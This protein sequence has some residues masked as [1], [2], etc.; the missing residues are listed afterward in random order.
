MNKSIPVQ[1]SVE[2][3]KEKNNYGQV[4]KETILDGTNRNV[5]TKR[6]KD[7]ETVNSTS[8]NVSIEKSATSIRNETDYFPKHPQRME[9]K[10]YKK[11]TSNSSLGNAGKKM[12]RNLEKQ[13]AQHN[14]RDS[15]RT[16]RVSQNLD[17]HAVEE[18]QANSTQVSLRNQNEGN[19]E[20]TSHLKSQIRTP[21]VRDTSSDILSK[22][23]KE[24]VNNTRGLH[25]IKNGDNV[26]LN[27][28]APLEN[29]VKINEPKKINDTAEK[30]TQLEKVKIN[31]MEKN[32]WS[33]VKQ[34][35]S[36]VFR[37]D[38]LKAQRTT[39]SLENE[40]KSKPDSEE[41]PAA[42]SQSEKL[43]G[44]GNKDAGVLDKVLLRLDKTEAIAKSSKDEQMVEKD[45]EHFHNKTFETD[46]RNSSTSSTKRAS[47]RI[48]VH[49]NR[50][51]EASKDNKTN[52][53]PERTDVHFSGKEEELKDNKT[54]RTSE[55]IV[56]DLNGKQEASKD[57][58]K[59]RT[60]EK[61]VVHL[62]GKQEPSLNNKNNNTL[63]R[64][65]ALL[66]EHKNT[67]KDNKTNR[68]SER[69]VVDLNGKQ[70]ASKDN[71]TK[72]T[73]EKMVV[74]LNGKQEALKYNKGNNTSEKTVVHLNEKQASKDKNSN[75]APHRTVVHLNGKQDALEGNKTNIAV[76]VGSMVATGNGDH[77][78]HAIS[79]KDKIATEKSSI[80]RSHTNEP[81][82]DT[83]QES[84][85]DSG[86][87]K[88]PHFGSGKMENNVK[89][90]I[91]LLGKDEKNTKVQE[92]RI[93][94]L[95]D[96]P[97]NATNYHALVAKAKTLNDHE[98]L[99]K[100]KKELDNKEE[101]SHKSERSKTAVG[102][103]VGKEKANST[104]VH[105]EFQ[106]LQ[107]KSI[108]G[109]HEVPMRG[110]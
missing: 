67:S 51:Q 28:N 44:K 54:K 103:N 57:N 75:N 90:S 80:K 4:G 83:E 46:S 109:S 48:I 25:D 20:K 100:K 108:G 13:R 98:D 9:V 36:H 5:S 102:I 11:E 7:S 19:Y 15:E 26:P 31:F 81:Q 24:S 79:E 60:S 73:S 2:A 52:Y 91:K 21:N 39:Q 97:S 107:P 32:K 50:N 64:I 95:L 65:I 8:S 16:Q 49:L 82:R 110:M 10:K 22:S 6:E 56:E 104:Q 27:T 18:N 62:N 59:K 66:N 14:M 85:V 17:K 34:N 38:D 40:S 47:E 43:S 70:E 89:N 1:T 88:N 53:T 23:V 76:N 78:T 45:R 35:D 68:T 12:E 86:N 41:K 69:I 101:T 106:N 3:S 30:S 63:E 94:K 58:K 61:I 74:D 87:T 33:H 84:M 55:K 77:H 93:G 29:I 71:K 99:P 96:N 72:R 92:K 42:M 105:V 37:V